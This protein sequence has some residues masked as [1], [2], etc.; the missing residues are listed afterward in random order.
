ME[1]PA[2]CTVSGRCR[3]TPQRTAVLGLAVLTL[4]VLLVHG[5]HPRA[6][7]GG[8][9]F[10]GVEQLLQPSLFPLDRPFVTAPTHYS[11]FAPIVAWLVRLSHAPLDSVLLGLYLFTT[12]LLLHAALGLSRRCFPSQPGAQW[13]GVALL[14]AWWTLPVAGT[15]LLLMDPYLTARSFSTPLTLLALNQILSLQPHHDLY[16]DLHHDLRDQTQAI[17]HRPDASHA[18]HGPLL[19]CVVILAVIAAVHPLMAIHAGLF[20]LTLALVIRRAPPWSFALLAL[21]WI[22]IVGA[23]QATGPPEPFAVQRAV[24]SRYYWFLSNWRWFEWLGLAGPL[25]VL[26]AIGRRPRH[27]SA[28]P[29]PSAT[30]TLCRGS[31][32]LGLLSISVSLLFVQEHFAAHTAARL[33]PLRSFLPIY[34]L[35]PLLLGGTLWNLATSRLWKLALPCSIVLA[36]AA[37]MFAVQRATFP[38]SP[39]IEWPGRVPSNPWAEAFLWARQN[40]PPDALFALDARYINTAGEDAQNFRAWAGRSTVPDFSKDGGEAANF[41][42]L[43]PAWLSGARATANLSQLSDAERTGRLDGFGVSW[44]ILQ[45]TAKTALPCPYRNDTVKVCRR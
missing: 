32:F 25:A 31:L 12:M 42:E 3:R 9:Y 35:L 8:L 30:A 7:D 11:L 33:Q 43:A 45:S 16:D 1:I 37:A 36:S 19:R 6:E 4:A 18:F 38:Q 39:H 5:F 22:G 21:A 13:A 27:R 41:P 23:L 2:Y 34:A 17:P 14:A 26:F 40:T 44:L 15:S 20:T 28:A 29:S 24:Q 10:S